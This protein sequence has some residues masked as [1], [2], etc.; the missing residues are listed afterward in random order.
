MK[1]VKRFLTIYIVCFLL[2][3]ITNACCEENWQITGNGIITARDLISGN[4]FTEDTVGTITG[5][6]EILINPKTISALSG[7]N[8]SLHLTPTIYANSCEHHYINNLIKNTFK[9]SCNKDITLDG[10]L[11]KRGTNLID[12]KDVSHYIAFQNITV[13]FSE[14]FINKAEFTDEEY[15]FKSEIKTTDGLELVNTIRLK[16]EIE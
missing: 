14:T 10:E 7:I 2:S 8:T 15:E 11:I 5:E 12:L 4:V 6:F 1:K 9:I 3:I 13:S 16:F